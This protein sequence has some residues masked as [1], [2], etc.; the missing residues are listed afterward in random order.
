VVV[1][2]EATVERA[3][4]AQ[5]LSPMDQ[6]DLEDTVADW[7]EDHDVD[8]AYDLAGVLA[9]SGLDPAWADGVAAVVEEDA[10]EPVLRWLA[11][12]VETEQLMREIEDATTRISTLLAAVKQY[13][14]MDRTPYEHVDLVEGIDSTLTML[15]RRSAGRSRSSATTAPTCPPCP[16]TAPSSTR[17]GPTSSTTRCRPWAAAGR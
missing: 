11:Y 15:G 5:R 12:T 14:G 10:L 9:G 16:A 4:K 3:A 2:Q 13:S 6:S 7:L 8:G 1:L 17:C